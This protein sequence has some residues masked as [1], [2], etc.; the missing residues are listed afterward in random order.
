MKHF[1][2]ILA[3]ILSGFLVAASLTAVFV[4]VAPA[5]VLKDWTLKT[6]KTSYVGGEVLSFTSSSTKLRKADGIA[7]RAIECDR[8]NDKT[9]AY[10]IDSVEVGRAPGY[11][12]KP[13]E[14]VVPIRITNKPATCRLII[15]TDYKLYFFRHTIEYAASN[16]F[17]IL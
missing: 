14:I 5:D 8:P 6:S 11:N 12:S 4:S 2:L 9:V 7:Y 3:N 13:A 15:T 10:S 1:E 17:Q 16:D